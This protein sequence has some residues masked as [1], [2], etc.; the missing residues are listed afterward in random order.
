MYLLVVF[1]I[2][3]HQRR[4]RNHLKLQ[5]N[6]FSNWTVNGEPYPWL[7]QRGSES[8]DC[9]PP[10]VEFQ[11]EWSYTPTS[12]FDFIACL[13][14]TF[15][16]IITWCSN[17]LFEK[18]C[19]THSVN[20]LFILYRHCLHQNSTV[21]TSALLTLTVYSFKTYQLYPCAYSSL[22]LTSSFFD[23]TCV[24]IHKQSHSIR[25][26]LHY[27]PYHIIRERALMNV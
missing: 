11:I 18:L 2:M 21:N 19:V 22:S 26:L 15:T 17:F 9:S 4:V 14:T 24:C 10:S 23:C 27:L 13:G 7:K 20:K 1:L 12:P 3:T 25:S 6:T 16:S 5:S 8:D